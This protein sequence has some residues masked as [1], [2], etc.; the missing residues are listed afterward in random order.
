MTSGLHV[1]SLLTK[2]PLEGCVEFEGV[3]L[4]LSECDSS[5]GDCPA[6]AV[7][8]ALS[9]FSVFDESDDEEHPLSIVAAVT[10]MNKEIN[11][12]R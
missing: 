3:G 5:L 12:P 9:A 7:E 10:A 8:I 4:E 1:P 2:C 11:E 6:S